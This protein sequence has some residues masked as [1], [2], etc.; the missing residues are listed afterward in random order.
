MDDFIKRS[1][2]LELARGYYSQGLK[3][4]A[5]PVKA[6]RNI[7]SADVAEVK[8]GKWIVSEDDNKI[9]GCSECHHVVFGKP[10]FCSRCGARMMEHE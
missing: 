4:E 7:P 2:A 9:F 8:R 3:E 1:D 5:V 10:N 6:I